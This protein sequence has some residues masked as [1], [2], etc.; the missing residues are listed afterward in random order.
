MRSEGCIRCKGFREAVEA[1]EI[2]GWDDGWI[3]TL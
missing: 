3:S 2:V 1:W